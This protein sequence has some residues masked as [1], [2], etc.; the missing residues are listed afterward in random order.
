MQE[1][2]SKSKDEASGHSGTFVQQKVK[3][4]KR[5]GNSG[6]KKAEGTEKN[7]RYTPKTG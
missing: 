5:K 6:K 1:K 4:K 3:Q 2:K 7:S